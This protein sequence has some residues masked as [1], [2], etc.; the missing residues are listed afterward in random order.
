[1]SYGRGRH[2]VSRIGTE[3]SIEALAWPLPS[4]RDIKGDGGWQRGAQGLQLGLQIREALLAFTGL[5]AEACDLL[6]EE[7]C[8]LAAA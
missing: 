5:P 8:V 4:V 7:S 6:A 2:D 3:Y 1:M